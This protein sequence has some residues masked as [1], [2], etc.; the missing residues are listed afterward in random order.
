MPSTPALLET[1]V[2]FFAPLSRTASIKVSGMPQRPKPP[3][4]S[5]MPSLTSPAIA[6]AALA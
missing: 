4:I 3:A 5:I 1:K 6:S 2:R